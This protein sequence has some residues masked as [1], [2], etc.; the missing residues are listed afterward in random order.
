MESQHL[1][2]QD[3]GR[4]ASVKVLPDRRVCDQHTH[5]LQRSHSTMAEPSRDGSPSSM[6]RHI[7]RRSIYD[8][9]YENEHMAQ[10]PRFEPSRQQTRF[11]GD[12]LDFRRPVMSA[13]RSI[14]RATS[15][16]QE[17]ETV[18]L[19]SD[20]ENSP[21][22]SAS[23]PPQPRHGL[24]RFPRDI[25][26]ITDDEPTPASQDFGSW[27]MSDYDIEEAIEEV[28]PISAAAD[29]G[30][31]VFVDSRPRSRVTTQS[32]ARAGAQDRT[33]RSRGS[34]FIDLTNADDDV[35]FV[36]SRPINIGESSASAGVAARP[37]L[38]APTAGSVSAFANF[39]SPA[40]FPNL[41]A[42][43]TRQLPP[44]PPARLGSRASAFDWVLGPVEP[45]LVN[46]TSNAA[47]G[48]TSTARPWG[49][50]A[51]PIGLGG[52]DY[53]HVSFN[54][55]PSM[56]TESAPRY[57]EPPAAER[58]F[59]RSPREDEAVVCPNCGDELAVGGDTEK[60]CEVWVIKQCGHVSRSDH[61]ILTKLT[62][63]QAYC[64]ACMQ[65]R[66]A[67]QLK[68]RKT[69]SDGPPRLSTCVVEGCKAKANRK[70]MIH[71]FLSA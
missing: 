42:H 1:D 66:D 58:G 49:F 13:A 57:E 7:P 16:N 10:R 43:I 52:L 29:L 54:V 51:G 15:I 62:V 9:H 27:H 67:P 31:I 24:P 70:T 8:P 56:R 11:P 39:F 23:Q 28:A 22:I 3:V 47:N 65:R 59:T 19:T 25:I 35:V 71:V 6:L 4:R 61:I 41:R 40:G 26:D 18:D 33:Q 37:E 32:P 14:S 12:G 2:S 63:A 30:D 5:T 64:G 68:R 53:G 48:T 20:N 46:A 17:L 60:D 21:V 44:L 36:D 50:G 34:A 69:S 45:P 38:S 55:I